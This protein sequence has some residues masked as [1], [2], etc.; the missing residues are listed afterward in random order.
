MRGKG[1]DAQIVTPDYRPRPGDML[2][3]C[4]RA[5]PNMQGIA[6][7]TRTSHGSCHLVQVDNP[8]NAD[9]R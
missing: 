3:W 5:R 7:R 4:D 6:A 1:I 2:T 9:A 8:G